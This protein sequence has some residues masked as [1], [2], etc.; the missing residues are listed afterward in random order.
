MAIGT[1]LTDMMFV[2]LA[3]IHDPPRPGVEG[4]VCKLLESGV[5]V[6]M[7]TGDSKDTATSVG[8]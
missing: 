4:A 3:A 6:K 2:G 8:T 5:S 1:G 7:L